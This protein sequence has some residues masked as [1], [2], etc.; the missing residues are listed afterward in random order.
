MFL[1]RLNFGPVSADTRPEFQY[2]AIYYFL[3]LQIVVYRGFVET[4]G[5]KSMCYRF[6]SPG[7]IQN[8]FINSGTLFRGHG[9][10]FVRVMPR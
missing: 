6:R 3:M 10:G 2:N 7:L 8:L 5:K 4:C 9:L 1:R